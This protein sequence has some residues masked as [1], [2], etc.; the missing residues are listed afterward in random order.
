MASGL[1]EGDFDS[2]NVAY[3]IGVVTKFDNG[4]KG[5]ALMSGGSN[6][7]NTWGS[8]SSG[9]NPVISIMGDS[10]TETTDT[11]TI[12]SATPPTLTTL[13]NIIPDFNLTFTATSTS[14]E[15]VV[16][17]RVF[18]SLAVAVLPQHY[19]RLDSDD[20]GTAGYTSA[21]GQYAP[22]FQ[23]YPQERVKT[24]FNL[25]NLNIGQEYEIHPAFYYVS[26]CAF[27][28]GGKSGISY[29]LATPI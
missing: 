25:T 20:T 17:M 11:L 21:N 27:A 19:I 3:G 28:S 14:Y 24:S 23:Q 6:K 1:K 10:A 12:G 26:F 8:V 18:P 9:S 4:L 5:Q 7:S 16:G 22:T 13:M 2:L 15:I 29:I